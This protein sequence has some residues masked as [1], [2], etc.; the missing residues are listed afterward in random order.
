MFI[1]L[2]YVYLCRHCFCLSVCVF[3][4]SLF[5]FF[6][7]S[8]TLPVGLSVRLSYD[9]FAIILVNCIGTVELLESGGGGGGGGG[10]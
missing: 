1:Y 9:P 7:L 8:S 3:V 10:G 4:P 2:T 6:C 5:L